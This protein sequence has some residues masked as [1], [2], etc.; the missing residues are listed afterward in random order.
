MKVKRIT[1]TGDYLNVDFGDRSVRMTGE[2]LINGFVV[3]KGGVRKWTV[4]EGK[5][6]TEEELKEIKGAV[7]EYVKDKKFVIAFE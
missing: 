6:V 1:G 2:L 3:Y 4:P 5:T 7:A